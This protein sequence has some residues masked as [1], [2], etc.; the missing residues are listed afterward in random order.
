MSSP[1]APLMGQMNF[2]DERTLSV[3]FPSK[4][5][6]KPTRTLSQESGLKPFSTCQKSE[7]S[8]TLKTCMLNSIQASDFECH[9]YVIAF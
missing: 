7:L 8:V 5:A 1:T 3:V 4:A 2:G 9:T 6:T